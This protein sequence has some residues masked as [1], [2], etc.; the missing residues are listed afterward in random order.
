MYFR[1]N[2][3]KSSAVYS[4]PSIV[5]Y[6]VFLPILLLKVAAQPG[7]PSLNAS[8]ASEPKMI[9]PPAKYITD[10]VMFLPSGFGI[11]SACPVFGFT[12]AAAEYVVPR[13]IP[14]DRGIITQSLLF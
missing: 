6:G 8:S 12:N 10:G 5:Q 4:W 14:I 11:I 3:D 2:D 1:S 13:S 9:F 7:R